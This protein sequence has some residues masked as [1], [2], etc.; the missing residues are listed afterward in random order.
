MKSA[1]KEMVMRDRDVLLNIN[2]AGEE[3]EID[4]ETVV[5]VIDDSELLESNGGAGYALSLSHK[6]VF[7]KCEDL[8]G[9]KG[10]G[11]ELMIDGIPYMVQSWSEKMGLAQIVL[12]ITFNT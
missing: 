9:R 1:F 6:T 10:Y 4:G 5:C 11:E 3:H 12:N 7:A 8:P 2:E